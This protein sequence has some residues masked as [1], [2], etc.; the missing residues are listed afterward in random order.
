[1]TSALPSATPVTSKRNYRSSTGMTKIAEEV[2]RRQYIIVLESCHNTW[3]FD[4]IRMQFCRI[5]KGIRVA[6]RFVATMWRPYWQ[7]ELD[8]DTEAFSVYLDASG[9]RL[10]QSWR[11]NQYC[12]LC[13]SRRTA[14]LTLEDIRS[15]V[16]S[17]EA[18]LPRSIRASTPNP[19]KERGPI[20]RSLSSCAANRES[21]RRPNLLRQQISRYR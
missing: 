18:T 12:D 16:Q 2:L 10:I 19:A 4:P 21:R 7:L 15:I 20:Q 5:P 6:G 1:M 14:E 9:T 13:G 8:P 17:S 11:H 3:V